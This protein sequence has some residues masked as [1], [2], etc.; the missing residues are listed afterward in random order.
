MLP[1]WAI[2]T[3]ETAGKEEKWRNGTIARVSSSG[4]ESQASH[5]QSHHRLGQSFG[6]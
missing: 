2:G 1:G 4:Y 5:H 3:F 6:H